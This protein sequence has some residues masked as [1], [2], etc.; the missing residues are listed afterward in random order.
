MP[1]WTCTSV[2]ELVSPLIGTKYIHGNQIKLANENAIPLG[3]ESSYQVTLKMLL[4]LA[5]WCWPWE[6]C[7]LGRVYINNTHNYVG[8]KAREII[9]TPYHQHNLQLPEQRGGGL[10][11]K[12]IQMGMWTLKARG[13]HTSTSSSTHTSYNVIAIDRHLF[14]WD[15]T[16]ICCHSWDKHKVD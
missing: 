7:D 16:H 5:T 14:G 15:P 8:T 4:R 3:H 11:S 10:V 9:T 12:T 6:I 13:V 1:Q 2:E